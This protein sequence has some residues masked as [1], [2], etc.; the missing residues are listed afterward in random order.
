M[1]SEPQLYGFDSIDTIQDENAC[2]LVCCRPTPFA[3]VDLETTGL[4][5]KVNEI[6]E[7]AIVL[8]DENGRPE[9]KHFI[10]RVKPSN[11]VDASW[12][13][14]ITEEDVENSPS[15][16]DISGNVLEFLA[17][18]TVVAHNAYFDVR[19]LNAELT[20]SARLVGDLNDEE[21][22]PLFPTVC[23]MWSSKVIGL[24]G[25][26]SL[27]RAC[28]S[29]GYV[30]ENAHAALDDAWA[31]AALLHEIISTARSGGE[32]VNKFGDPDTSPL[33]VENFPGLAAKKIPPSTL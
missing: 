11:G 24:G 1:T 30:N 27:Q 12:I 29:I 25:R 33:S 4:D 21:R 28:E 17:G 26:V 8:C 10:S 7:V 20:R 2:S 13:H 19:F 16:L 31:A 6:I 5:P 14:G 23:T 32:H 3:V 15:F 22:F 9:G 18:R